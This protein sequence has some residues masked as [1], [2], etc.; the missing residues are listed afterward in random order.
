MPRGFSD[1]P[2]GVVYVKTAWLIKN[3]FTVCP[4]VIVCVIGQLDSLKS[5]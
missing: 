1:Y 2:T 5:Y 4:A 3:L